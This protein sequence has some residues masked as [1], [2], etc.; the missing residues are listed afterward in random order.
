[1]SVARRSA[2]PQLDHR[3]DVD[4]RDPH[5]VLESFGGVD[6]WLD[7]VGA[8]TI[9]GALA[10]LE[11]KPSSTP[12]ADHRRC[13]SCGSRK[14]R[15]KKSNYDLEHMKA[16][17][18]RC[19]ECGKHQN[20]PAPPLSEVDDE[21]DWI[22]NNAKGTAFEWVV[23][24]RDLPEKPAPGLHP[25]LPDLEERDREEAVRWAVLLSRPWDDDGGLTLRETAEHIPYGRGFVYGAR[26]EWRDGEHPA[27]TAEAALRVLG[28]VPDAV[29][30]DDA[31]GEGGEA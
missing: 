11:N 10:H 26:E 12:A 28:S 15:A 8:D 19:E 18:Y 20:D 17:S 7:D 4:P 3:E 21:V 6:A 30:G 13:R 29:L 1:V 14:V 5:G 16:E 31:D 22:A 2:S 24:S 27:V 23:D 25:E 9:A